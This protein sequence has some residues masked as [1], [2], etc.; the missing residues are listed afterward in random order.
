MV[1]GFLLELVSLIVRERGKEGF[2]GRPE[3]V[4]GEVGQWL[5]EFC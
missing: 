4:R 1:S 2:E 5:E 3:G